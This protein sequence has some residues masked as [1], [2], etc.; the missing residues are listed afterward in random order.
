MTLSEAVGALEVF[1]QAMIRK[2]F[3]NDEEEDGG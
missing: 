3:D 2:G 1:Q